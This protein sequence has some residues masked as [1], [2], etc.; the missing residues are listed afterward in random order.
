MPYVATNYLTNP[1]APLGKWVCSR[2]SPLS[3]FATEPPVEKK[4]GPNFCGQCVSYVT[5]VCPTIPVNTH[6][7]KKGLQVKGKLDIKPG[8]A[9]ATFDQNG[10]YSGHT[11]IYESQDGQGIAVVDQW[12]T[13]P[14]KAI[15]RRTL[16]FGAH[17]NS[18]NGDNFF[19]V[20]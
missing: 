16:R 2:A 15:H 9:I 3:A 20:E 12:V 13:P 6:M 19:V 1:N 5:Q 7:W 4:H 17:G 18:N 8:T 11:A 10:T 14:A